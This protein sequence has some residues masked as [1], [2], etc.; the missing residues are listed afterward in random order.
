MHRA[1]TRAISSTSVPPTLHG[2]FHAS[3]KPV[4]GARDPMFRPRRAA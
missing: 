3:P 4:V 1:G 2:K